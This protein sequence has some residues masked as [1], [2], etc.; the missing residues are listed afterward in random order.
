MNVD[1]DSSED[2]EVVTCQDSSNV[3][4]GMDEDQDKIET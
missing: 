3:D 2:R 4:V 1:V